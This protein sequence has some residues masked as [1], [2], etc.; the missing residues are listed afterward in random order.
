MTS[1]EYLAARTIAL[2]HAFI[3]LCSLYLADVTS[4]RLDAVKMLRENLT[5]PAGQPEPARPILEADNE[6]LG[7][8]VDSAERIAVELREA[9]PPR[10]MR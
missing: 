10:R 4:S 6:E 9:Y 8:L 2:E 1:E 5:V 7:L 3:R